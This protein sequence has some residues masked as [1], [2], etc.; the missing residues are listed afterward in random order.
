ME[1]EK[2]SQNFRIPFPVTDLQYSLKKSNCASN[3]TFVQK[4]KLMTLN[5]SIAH[6]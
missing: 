2:K 4:R 6:K 3:K 1:F 5:K